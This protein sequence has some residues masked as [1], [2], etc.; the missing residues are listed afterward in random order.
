LSFTVI[1]YKSVYQVHRIY[2]LIT[3]WFTYY[4]LIST[5]L[6]YDIY[7]SQSLTLYVC[8]FVCL[9]SFPSSAKFAPKLEC[10]QGSDTWVLGG[11]T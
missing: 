1:N 7:Y 5:L 6:S 10:I 4:L 8:L 2:L 9:C 11:P 3:Y